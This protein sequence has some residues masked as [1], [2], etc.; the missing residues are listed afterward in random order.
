MSDEGILQTLAGYPFAG[1]LTPEQVSALAVGATPFRVGPG[2]VLAREHDDAV[3]FY[4]I[5]SGWVALSAEGGRRGRCIVQRVGPGEAVGWSWLIPP[6]LWQFSACAEDEV[7]GYRFDGGW[8]RD[9]C[10]RENG[11]GNA[12]LQY[13]AG[14]LACRLA[15]TRRTFAGCAW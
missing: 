2:A 6:H 10:A 14:V 4:L 12:L 3:S 15:A 5:T 7:R 8:L 9:L 13:V 11:I 1:G